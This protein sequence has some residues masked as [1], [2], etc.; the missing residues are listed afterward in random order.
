MMGDV[1]VVILKSLRRLIKSSRAKVG[2]VNDRS[3]KY[4]VLSNQLYQSRTPEVNR[5][6]WQVLSKNVLPVLLNTDHCLKYVDG[7]RRGPE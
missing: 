4:P 7:Y 6:V 5:V 3:S 1:G 2:V